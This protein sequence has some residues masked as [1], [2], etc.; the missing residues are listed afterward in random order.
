MNTHRPLSFL[1]DGT[2]CTD[3]NLTA[4]FPRSSREAFGHSDPAPGRITFL[5]RGRTGWAG[6]AAVVLVLAAVIL[7][8]VK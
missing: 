2:A 4:R 6:I 8:S 1:I 3:D 7:W 5:Q